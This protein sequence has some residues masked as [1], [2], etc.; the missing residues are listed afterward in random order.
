MTSEGATPVRFLHPRHGVHQPR[1]APPARRPSSVRRTMTIDTIRPH[2]VDGPVFQIG[3]ARDLRTAPDGTVE[4]LGAAEARTEMGGAPLYCL[5]SISSEPPRP[6]L[7]ALCGL[8]VSSGFRAAMWEQVPAERAEATLLHSL[9]DDL[10]GAAL[11]SGYTIMTAGAQPRPRASRDD[12]PA[13]QFEG[14]C[15][16]YQSGGTIVTEIAA[17]G[18]SPTP[19]GPAAPPIV[20]PADSHSWHELRPLGPSDVRRWRIL[21]VIDD[22]LP[23]QVR[24]EVYFRDSHVGGEPGGSPGLETVLH[25]YSVSAVVDIASETVVACEARAHS[26]PWAECIEAEASGRRLAGM[27]LRGLRPIV[28]DEFVGVTTC[29]HLNDTL[30]SV[31]DVRALLAHVR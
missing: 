14:L 3:A 6:S 20:D 22:G 13:V 21:D 8:P 16:G 26:L 23:S 25:E 1:P 5:A 2:G 12:T 29:T 18:L 17:T 31:E 4:V 30:R 24:V 15:A 9:L 28:R 10:P 11:V 7:E 27:A 19:T